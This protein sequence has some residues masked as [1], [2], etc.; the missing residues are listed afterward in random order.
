MNEFFI[1]VTKPKFFVM[2]E[3]EL[4][5]IKR[6]LRQRNIALRQ[7]L[8]MGKRLSADFRINSVLIDFILTRKNLSAIVAYVSD[9]AEP[10]LNS[11]MRYVLHSKIQLILPRFVSKH[12]YDMVHVNDLCFPVS[13]WGIPEPSSDARKADEYTLEHALWLVPGVAFD[14]SGYRLGRG[15]G[16]YDRLLSKWDVSSIGIYYEFQRYDKLPVES[17]DRPTKFIA[18]ELG[19]FETHPHL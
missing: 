19:I 3:I 13:H 7:N 17:T 4:Q 10:D 5:Q 2:N 9:G 11:V 1:A 18:T 8:D 16:V 12:D 14:S 15:A 6:N